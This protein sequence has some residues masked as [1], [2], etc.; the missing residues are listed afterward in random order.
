MALVGL[1]LYVGMT[2]VTGLHHRSSVH[3]YSVGCFQLLGL[4][5]GF[6]AMVIGGAAKRDDPD[7]GC[8]KVGYILGWILTILLTLTILV[9]S[10]LLINIA[11]LIESNRR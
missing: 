6:S 1:L 2:V 3:L 4:I 5:L 9:I 11:M 8:A 7:D 10:F